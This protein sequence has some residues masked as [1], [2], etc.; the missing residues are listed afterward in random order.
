ILLPRRGRSF[1]A[2]QPQVLLLAI[3]RAPFGLLPLPWVFAAQATGTV[4]A[5]YALWFEPQRLGITRQRLRSRKLGAGPPLKLLHFGDLH[6]ERST[7]RERALARAAEELAP[8]LVLF[9]G[10]FLSTS[11]LHDPIA[12]A[13]CRWVFS[14]LEP[15]L[16][17]FAVA[18]SPAV[19]RPDLLPRL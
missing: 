8:D 2:P 7:G 3:A 19:D 1:G 13:A 4:L 14:Q 16:G 11:C 12:R 17:T 9:S 18:G 6:M 10:D 5:I 15:R